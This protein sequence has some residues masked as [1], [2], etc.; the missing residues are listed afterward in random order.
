MATE[1]LIVVAGENLVDRIGAADG[2][3]DEAAGGGPFNTALALG[4]LGCR[5]AYLGRLST[6]ERG[7]RLSALLLD[8]GV[9][10]SLAIA[11]DDRTLV[12]AATLG[13]A[14]VAT[15]RFD[16][17]GSAASGLRPAD[18]PAALPPETIALHV[19]TLG[20]VLEPMASTIE[21]LVAKVQPRVLVMVDPNVRPSAVTDETR[22]RSRLARILERA[23]VVKASVEDLRWLRP[24]VDPEVAAR[25]LAEAGASV[26]LVTDGPRPVRVVSRSAATAVVD[27]PLRDVVDTVGAGDAFGAGF[28]A[29]WERAGRQR[30]DLEDRAAVLEAVRFAVNVAA[31][32][33]GRAGA[34]PPRPADLGDAG[35]RGR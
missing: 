15:Y 23:D 17:E 32:T 24:D 1:P 28:L 14:G 19:G 8:A 12:A 13:S 5:V 31:W 10:L 16:G 26:V 11:T 33:V 34:D 18:L 25:S 29:A 20:L 2:R 9:D 21:R 22:Y 6:D 35:E 3:I 30:K 4:R 27:V 7:R